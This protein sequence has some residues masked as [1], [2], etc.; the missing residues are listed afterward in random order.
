MIILTR[1][2]SCSGQTHR[3]NSQK[4]H[5]FLTGV[6]KVVLATNI[7]ETSITID[8]IVYVIDG[9]KAKEKVKMTRPVCF[10]NLLL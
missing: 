8:D 1:P 6:R 3:E 5:R 10:S 7:A 2:V 9:G 4:D